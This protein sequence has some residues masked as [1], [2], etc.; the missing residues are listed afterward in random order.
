MDSA[1]PDTICYLSSISA[2]IFYACVLAEVNL[3][4]L[5]PFIC[6]AIHFTRA[7]AE[8]IFSHRSPFAC[9]PPPALAIFAPIIDKPR[10][11]PL[12]A[13][14]LPRRT[15]QGSIP[16]VRVVGVTLGD[17]ARGEGPVRAALTRAAALVEI[18][19]GV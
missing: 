17:W 13:G 12:S 14:P 6:T 4:A 11:P 16:G 5:M 18:G 7:V 2:G 8:G 15:A 9:S 3:L 10:F 19:L 1:Q